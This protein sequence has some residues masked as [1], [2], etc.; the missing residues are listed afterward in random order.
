MLEGSRPGGP[1][2]GRADLLEGS[3]LASAVYGAAAALALLLVEL[4]LVL[5]LRRDEISSV[6]EVQHGASLLLPGFVLLALVAGPCGGLLLGLL[7]RA[8]QSRPHRV[9]LGLLVATGVALAGFGVG[10]GRHLAAP[11]VRVGFALAL[12]GVACAAVILLSRV[13]S[14][15]LKRAPGAFALAAALLVTLLELLNRF[16][17]VRLYPAFHVALALAALLLAPAVLLP[18]WQ[19]LRAPGATP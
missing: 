7:W 12:A 2:S 10:G 1:A 17:L 9:M 19:L 5:L 6:W 16:V 14:S 15:W 13:A 11:G 3:R 4:T 8:Q 18:L